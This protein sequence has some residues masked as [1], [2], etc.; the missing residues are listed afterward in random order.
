MHVDVARPLKPEKLL[1]KIIRRLYDTVQDENVWWLREPRVRDEL[2]SYASSS[3]SRPV[4]RQLGWWKRNR[5]RVA[6]NGW[7]GL[8]GLGPTLQSQTLR[9]R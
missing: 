9:L 8:Y 6:A 2:T 7:R 1:C 4:P 3:A 5:L